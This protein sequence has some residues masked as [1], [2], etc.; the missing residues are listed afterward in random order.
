M[1]SHFAV[2]IAT[3]FLTTAAAAQTTPPPPPEIGNRANGLNYEPTPRQVIPKERQAGVL[4]PPA[5]RK[6]NEAELNHIYR[7]LMHNGQPNQSAPA[8]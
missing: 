4:P 8:R 1:Q 7:N 6:A 5:Q 3:I 2:M